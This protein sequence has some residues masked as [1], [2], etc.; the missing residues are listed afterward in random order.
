MQ[1]SIT[2]SEKAANRVK[3]LIEDEGDPNLCL[4]VFISGGG[5]NGFSYGFTFDDSRAE[6]DA[7]I[8]RAGVLMLVDAM[9][10]PYLDGADVDYVEDLSGAQFVVSN[11]NAA[12]TCGCGSSLS[13]LKLPSVGALLT[14]IYC[15]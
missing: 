9:S 12:A 6:D 10:Y 5:C 2:F 1:T 11:P 15:T 4:R 8:E 14:G 7:V 3:R 13:L